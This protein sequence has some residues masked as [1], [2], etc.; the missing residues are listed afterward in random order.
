MAAGRPRVSV[1]IPTYNRAALL[2]AAIDSVLAQTFQNFEIIVAD[3]GSTDATGDLVR[4]YSARDARVRYV[5]LDHA[6]ISAA[7]NAGIRASARAL[8]ARVDSDDK[9]MP[10]LLEVTVA[11]LDARYFRGGSAARR[12][13]GLVCVV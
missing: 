8:I 11:A 6:G 7:L 2:G 9:W 3:D 10:N 5:R 13:S 12:Q 4:D 1:I